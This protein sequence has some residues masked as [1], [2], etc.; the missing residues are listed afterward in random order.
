MCRR[1]E[2]KLPPPDTGTDYGFSPPPGC[3]KDQMQN[4]V[5]IALVVKKNTRRNP[6]DMLDVISRTEGLTFIEETL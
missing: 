3:S 5:G 2:N 6:V 1:K 4:A